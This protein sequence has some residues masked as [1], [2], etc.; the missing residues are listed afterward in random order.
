MGGR[1][2]AG[3]PLGPAPASA[4]PY[5]YQ[6]G[7]SRSWQVLSDPLRPAHACTRPRPCR[8]WATEVY[9]PPLS[10]Q[11]GPL[12]GQRR[13]PPQP[14]AGAKVC[15]QAAD[16]GRC[17]TSDARQRSR[18]MMTSAVAAHAHGSAPPQGAAGGPVVAVA[19]TAAVD[20]PAAMPVAPPPSLPSR[21][22][23]AAPSPGD[24]TARAALGPL[25]SPAPPLPLPLPG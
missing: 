3:R 15:G 13:R 19:A 5:R 18:E 7:E 6:R 12:P 9:L 11:C 25:E 2:R 22:G 10:A 4:V 21:E 14:E 16:T 20:S 17:V 8:G 24:T 23:G 1:R